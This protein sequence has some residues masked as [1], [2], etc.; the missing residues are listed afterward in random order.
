VIVDFLDDNYV[1][2]T[3]PKKITGV[4]RRRVNINHLLLLKDKINIQRAASDEEVIS[5]LKGKKGY[6]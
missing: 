1:T 5:A 6:G 4:R 2:I 3:G